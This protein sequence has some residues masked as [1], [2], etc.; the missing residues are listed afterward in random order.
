MFE[1]SGMTLLSLADQSRLPLFNEVT[2]T[3]GQ[4]DAAHM[5]EHDTC[6]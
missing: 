1:L 3:Y 6:R 4:S 5:K 2:S